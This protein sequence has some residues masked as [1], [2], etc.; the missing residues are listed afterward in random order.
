MVEFVI[1]SCHMK[2]SCSFYKKHIFA[3]SFVCYYNSVSRKEPNQTIELWVSGT[4]ADNFCLR[5]CH[6]VGL[7]KISKETE[8]TGT[9]KCEP[10]TYFS[11]AS[12][13]LP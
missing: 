8:I 1:E 6:A 3:Q 10:V 2:Y 7:F 13:L 5:R 12:Y 11:S 4:M 9:K